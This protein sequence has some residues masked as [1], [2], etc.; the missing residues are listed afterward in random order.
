V[1]NQIRLPPFAMADRFSEIAAL[2]I[3]KRRLAPSRRP[4]GY[5]KI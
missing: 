3:S 4:N 5:P 1:G 2:E